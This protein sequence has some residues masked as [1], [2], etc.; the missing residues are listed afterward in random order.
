MSTQVQTVADGR[1][2]RVFL[3]GEIDHCAA[4]RLRETI[5]DRMLTYRPC[6]L[7]LDFSG[8]SFMDSSGVGLV[9]GRYR[10]AH[11]LGC[12]VEAANLSPRHERIMKMSGLGKI[13]RFTK[14]K[15]GGEHLEK[16][17]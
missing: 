9:M 12:C 14:T 8:V 7:Q 1:T 10:L 2:L 4:P 13:V 5:D 17:Q 16:A 15:Q 6:V 11:T 3:R